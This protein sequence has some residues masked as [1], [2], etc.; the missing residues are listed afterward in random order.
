MKKT[1]K[2]IL[3]ATFAL[4]IAGNAQST[5][6]SESISTA[7]P[8]LTIAPDSRAAGIGDAG[9]ATS[10]DFFS[11]HWNAAKYAFINQNY[12]VGIS[13]SPWMK[14]LVDDMSLSYLSGFYKLDENQAISASLRYLALGSFVI[15]DENN[16][17]HSEQ[18]PNEFA[19]DF[20][21]SRKLS[22]TWSGAV[23]LRYIR[24]NVGG[25]NISDNTTTPGNAFAVD[26]AFLF[27]STTEPEKNAISA[28]IVASN[29][30]SPVSYDDGN[31]KD[32]LPA[33]LRLGTAYHWQQS[34][35]HSFNFALDFNKLMVPSTN[36]RSAENW[37]V[38]NGTS[39]DYSVMGSIVR[40]FSDS[41]L[42][43]EMQEITTSLGVEYWYANQIA[44]RTGYFRE[45]ENKGGR[46]YLTFG[47]G[48]KHYGISFDLSY[49]YSLASS[50]PLE[51]TF[52]FS[53]GFDLEQL[54]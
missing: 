44:V 46:E 3:L 21:Y 38:T 48:A 11:Q 10:A 41:S 29:I 25:T 7:V 27:R 35:E 34:T 43:E 40:S 26:V 9:V 51:N 4:P 33:N 8:F 19:F 36:Y 5:T 39:S 16:L 54:F 12:G 30:G 37:V 32:F 45:N 49:L 20:A 24:S 28:G 17:I 6:G 1:I 52:R 13:Y 53:L 50:S 22:Q 47:A 14:K 42:K 15:R 23:T 31:T 2:A 18:N